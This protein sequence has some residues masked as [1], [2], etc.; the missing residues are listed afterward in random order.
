MIKI[1]QNE[2]CKLWIDFKF[3]NKSVKYLE[4][5]MIPNNK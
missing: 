4:S 3:Q 1:K 2:N 5:K